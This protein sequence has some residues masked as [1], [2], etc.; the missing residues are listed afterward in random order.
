MPFLPY[1]GRSE[2]FTDA[3][4]DAYWWCY[5][6]LSYGH[7]LC[8]HRLTTNATWQNTFNVNI[9]ICASSDR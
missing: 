6:G 7:D 8:S 2:L 5:A 4:R 9:Y 1:I 3:C